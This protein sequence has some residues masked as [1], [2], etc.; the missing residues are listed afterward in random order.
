MRA[1]GLLFPVTR[2]Y[3]KRGYRFHV[4]SKLCSD[5]DDTVPLKRNTITRVQG[6]KK[7][8]SKQDLK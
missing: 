4:L 7:K 5:R 6:K 2:V 1:R 8:I 3:L